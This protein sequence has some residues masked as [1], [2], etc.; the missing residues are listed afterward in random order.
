MVKSSGLHLIL[1]RK[2]ENHKFVSNNRTWLGGVWEK[3]IS[4]EKTLYLLFLGAIL[5]GL[6]K[7]S[8]K[9]KSLLFTFTA[10]SRV[11]EKCFYF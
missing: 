9:V 10:K 6:I 4:F 3:N 2:N 7:D 5:I 1:M 8:N 11:T